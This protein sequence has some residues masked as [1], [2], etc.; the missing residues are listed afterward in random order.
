MTQLVPAAHYPGLVENLRVLDGLVLS[1]D[2][3]VQRLNAAVQTLGWGTVTRGDVI[4]AL[5]QSSELWRGAWAVR[6]LAREISGHGFALKAEPTRLAAQPLNVGL[7][8]MGTGPRSFGIDIEDDPAYQPAKSVAGE[9]AL[10]RHF[11]GRLLEAS[12]GPLFSVK[13]RRVTT[14][15][16]DG[17][18]LPTV[19]RSVLLHWFMTQEFELCFDPIEPDPEATL[20]YIDRW[21]CVHAVQRL[22]SQPLRPDWQWTRD[23]RQAIEVLALSESVSL[24]RVSPAAAVY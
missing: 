24:K 6:L 2:R 7:A 12:G 13:H 16:S 23:L 9:V 1:L 10:W 8:T 22:D 3:H 20:L 5:S 19:A 15:P 14:A 4:R 17:Q 11:D 21:G 18:I